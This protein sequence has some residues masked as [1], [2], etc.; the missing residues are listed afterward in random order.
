MRKLAPTECCKSSKYQRADHASRRWA[1]LAS[2]RWADNASGRW[3]DYTSRRSV[4]VLIYR[5]IGFE[6]SE[7]FARYI[8]GLRRRVFFLGWKNGKDATM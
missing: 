7:S 5:T 4:D 6:L 1:D 3:A 2:R 8:S